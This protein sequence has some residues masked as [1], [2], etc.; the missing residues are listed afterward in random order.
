MNLFLISNNLNHDPKKRQKMT[1]DEHK[2]AN[3][4]LQPYT[5]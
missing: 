4:I 5:W 3:L 2:S 1:I